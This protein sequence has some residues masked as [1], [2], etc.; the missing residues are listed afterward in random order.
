[1]A[2]HPVNVVVV[3]PKT[4]GEALRAVAQELAKKGLQVHSSLDKMGL[5]TGAIEPE[6][7]NSL[8]EVPGVTFVREE[9]SYHLA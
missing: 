9:R 1:M 2:D 5:V 4:R 8:L 6:K 3:V 7:M